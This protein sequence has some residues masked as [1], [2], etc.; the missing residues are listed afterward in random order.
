MVRLSILS[1]T[2]QY[3]D[4]AQIYH[5]KLF[6]GLDYFLYA[7]KRVLQP[8]FVRTIKHYPRQ[9]IASAS[10]LTSRAKQ[11]DL[12]F[13]TGFNNFHAI[14]VCPE[15]MRYSL[16]SRGEMLLGSVIQG[17]RVPILVEKSERVI[18]INLEAV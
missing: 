2:A 13:V 4:P 14:D 12:I 3:L 15:R 10:L 5:Y 1:S 6:L 7:Q 9:V 18:I 17:S 16:T 8:Y 11:A